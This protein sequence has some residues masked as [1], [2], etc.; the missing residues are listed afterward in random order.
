MGRLSVQLHAPLR[1]CRVSDS[2][3]EE[4][5]QDLKEKLEASAP[6]G[7]AQAGGSSPDGEAAAQ[8]ESLMGSLSDRAQELEAAHQ[9]L[10]AELPTF[11]VELAVG[12][13]RE[14]LRIDIGSRN[15]DVEATVRHALSV[16][17]AG[18]SSCTIHLHPDDLQNCDPSRFRSNTK[19]EADPDIGRGD[20]HVTTPQG[21][22][23][24]DIDAALTRVREELL[25]A[26]R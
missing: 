5:T 6:N 16:A 18:R 21:L 8:L 10:E 7:E 17:S 22:L 11:A 3:L 15:Y 14:L 19:F 25:E 20:V 4:L 23:V 2:S 26:T 12:I 13:A 1:A 9:K 24:H